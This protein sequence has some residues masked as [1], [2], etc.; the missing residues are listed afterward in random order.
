MFQGLKKDI[1]NSISKF[2]WLHEL[3]DKLCYYS[4][5]RESMAHKWHT[6]WCIYT[7]EQLSL[8]PVITEDQ[9]QAL[10]KNNFFLE[11]TLGATK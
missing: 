1:K 9:F 5:N 10:S 3:A 6:K 11:G 8:Y 7:K 4:Q 2:R